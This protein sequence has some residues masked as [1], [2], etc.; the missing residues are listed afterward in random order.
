M[1]DDRD[2]T[3]DVMEQWREICEESHAQLE[4]ECE[5]LEMKDEEMA[6]DW[7]RKN[8]CEWCLYKDDCD[9]ENINCF[10]KNAFLAGLKAGRPKW[11]KPSEKLPEECSAVLAYDFEDSEPA[12]FRFV[13]SDTWEY[14]PR[15]IAWLSNDQ[16][17]S[18]CEIPKYTE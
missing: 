6:E 10:N 13:A 7:I 16:I 17:K 8:C 18:W 4:K 2:I 15:R 3:D 5:D 12:L 1:T 9:S 11:H 14:L